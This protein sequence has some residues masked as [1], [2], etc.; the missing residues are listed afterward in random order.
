MLED[1]FGPEI[2]QYIAFVF[3]CSHSKRGRSQEGIT[4]TVE[5]YLDERRN[6]LLENE[7][8]YYAKSATHIPMFA[9]HVKLD[10]I[11]YD[12][13]GEEELKASTKKEFMESEDTIRR[14]FALARSR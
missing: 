14:I 7:K 11:D 12:D 9:F 6:I 10:M 8:F 2:W 4:K 5:E 1:T 3:R 13:D